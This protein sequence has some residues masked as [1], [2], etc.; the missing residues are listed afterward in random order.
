MQVR[1]LMMFLEARDMASKD[2]DLQG[3]SAVAGEA[4]KS[5]RRRSRKK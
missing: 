2:A 1:D 5:Q 4:S 3:G